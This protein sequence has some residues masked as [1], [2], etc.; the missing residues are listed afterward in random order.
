M[1]ELLH[2]AGLCAPWF[3]V[4]ADDVILIAESKAEIEERLE[5]VRAAL[6][7]S[8]LMLS[9]EKT[10]YMKCNWKDKV[11]NESVHL[12]DRELR[13]VTQFKYLGALVQDDGNIDEDVANR[14]KVGWS[15]WRQASGVLCDKRCY[16]AIKGAVYKAMV[17]PALMFGAE[18]WAT[19]EEDMRKLEVAEMRML[20]WMGGFTRMD[21][22][23][24]EWFRDRFGV[25]NIRGKIR[26]SRL[27][28]Y[29]HIQRRDEN[30]AIK[31]MLR[32]RVEGE[33][34]RGRPKKTWQEVIRNDMKAC[35]LSDEMAW[36][37]NEWRMSICLPT[38]TKVGNTG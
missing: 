25:E 20:R 13:K 19:K 28:W 37:R 7:G 26:E 34:C 1:D 31:R 9:R 2:E 36:D 24:N 38:L 11:D 32:Y 8:G 16:P 27:R 4:Y 21:K 33:K 18:C 17:R 30:E 22:I 5:K 12:G 35:G 15:K 6:E 14:I 23:R 10:E 29:G 3:M